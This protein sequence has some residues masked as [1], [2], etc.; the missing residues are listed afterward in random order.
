MISALA[1]TSAA[2]STGTTITPLVSPRIMSLLRTTHPPTT[3]GQFTSTA[4]VVPCCPCTDVPREKAGNPIELISCTSR[5]RPSVTT[6]AMPRDLEAVAN[7]P[8][9]TPDVLPLGELMT[10]TCPRS[11]LST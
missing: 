1:A 6:P 9:K 8:P 2:C 7:S 4:V 3:T 11:A 5:T 10:I